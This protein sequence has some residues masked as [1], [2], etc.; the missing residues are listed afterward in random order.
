M[1]DTIP[2]IV[3][4]G[5]LATYVRRLRSSLEQ[6]PQEW[7][8]RDL[9]SYLEA[10]AG[11]LDDMEGYYKNRGERVPSTPDWKFVAELLTAASVYE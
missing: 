10:L 6:A 9:S 7:E 8:N 11:W 2:R 1:T 5:D 4:A 3:T